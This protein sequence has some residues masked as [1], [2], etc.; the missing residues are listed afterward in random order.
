VHLDLVHGWHRFG[1]FCQP[2]EV[3]RVE[4]RDTDVAGAT[5]GCELL[6]RF[7]RG[8]EVAVVAGR[9]RPVDEKEVHVVG[10]EIAERR[11]E[12]LP[13]IVGLVE[14]VVELAGD[15]DRFTVDA[16]VADTF[17]DLLLVSV[18]LGGV[19]VA[20][21]DLEGRF[22]GLSR[23]LGIDLEHAE[24]ELRDLLAVSERDV[25]YL[26]HIARVPAL[27]PLQTG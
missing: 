23:L 24:A 3:G 26:S 27:P 9:E 1:L 8:D 10:S 15:E 16:G 4:V 19:D 5:V 18:H 25:G 14:T 22:D 17:A 13:R 11:V 2:V 20:V 21:A 7:P 12:R 6:Q